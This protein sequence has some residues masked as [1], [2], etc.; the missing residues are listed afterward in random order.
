MKKN[1]V[2]WFIALLVVN[3]GWYFVSQ[4]SAS[5]EI[6]RPG[7]DFSPEREAKIGSILGSSVDYELEHCFASINGGVHEVSIQV[8]SDSTVLS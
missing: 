2:L 4:Q 3:T 1:H 5:Q 7:A 6:N 8:E